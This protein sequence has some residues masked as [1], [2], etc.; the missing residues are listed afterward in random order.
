MKF[1]HVNISLDNR[2]LLCHYTRVD[3]DECKSGQHNCTEPHLVC[4]NV[5]GSY[6]CER[7]TSWP[8]PTTTTTTTTTM[9]TSDSKVADDDD[10]ADRSVSL[11]SITNLNLL[12]TSPPLFQ[13][14][15]MT[16]M[17][18]T[19]SMT[20]LTSTKA[21]MTPSDSMT[22]D[23]DDDGDRSVSLTSV[24]DV[25]ATSL[26]LF[27]T[28]M[29]TTMMPTSTTTTT[30]KTSTTPLNSKTTDNDDHHRSPSITDVLS[31]TTAT[32]TDRSAPTSSSTSML[33]QP[34]A[35]NLNTCRPGY[36]FNRLTS[37]CEGD[38]H[39]L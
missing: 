6:R 2:T 7:S 18:P 27:K 15:T 4:V 9:A 14:T 12:P 22:A 35:V 17:M 36:V 28:T 21:T 3:L 39:V 1:H 23:N 13:T 16:T 30:T 38:Q 25:P 5:P 20:R 31:K 29:T 24:A 19:T 32:T 26:P 37:T 33:S 8:L 34:V 10:S 11:A